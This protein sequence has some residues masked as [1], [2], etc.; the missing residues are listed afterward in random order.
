MKDQM[1]K[2][3]SCCKGFGGLILLLVLDQL[4]KLGAAVFLKDRG[5]VT[6]L[7][8]IFQL[9]Y[10]ENRGAAFGMLENMQWIFVVFALV[11]TAAAV[12]FYLHIP[13]VRRFMILRVLCVTLSAG[14]LGNMID[15]LLHGDV[16]DFFYFR[17][18]DFP[19]FNVADIYVCASVAVLLLVCLFYYKEE[20][21]ACLQGKKSREDY[22][23]DIIDKIQESK[24]K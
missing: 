24:K 5:P 16:I 19:I 6:I 18:I 8:G 3:I 9:Q 20:D 2:Y 22:V 13:P 1:S 11:I 15:R 12:W 7:P 4:T 17:L 21:F 14:A 23:H 10:L